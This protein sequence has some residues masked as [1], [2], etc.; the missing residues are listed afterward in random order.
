MF[1]P[2]MLSAHKC[3]AFFLLQASSSSTGESRVARATRAAGGSPARLH[4]QRVPSSTRTA[5]CRQLGGSAFYLTQ[6]HRES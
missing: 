3:V 6:M 4:V 1:L 5:P 2:D